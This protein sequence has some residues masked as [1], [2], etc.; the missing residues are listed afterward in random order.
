MLILLHSFR[1][2][3]LSHKGVLKI[4]NFDFYCNILNM[5]VSLCM[6]C[7]SQCYCNFDF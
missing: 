4:L 5:C 2:F 3:P 7:L 6:K 1:N